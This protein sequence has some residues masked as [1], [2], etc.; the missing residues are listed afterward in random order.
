[1]YSN[2][3]N[4]ISTCPS[5]LAK[6]PFVKQ[7]RHLIEMKCPFPRTFSL[8]YFILNNVLIFLF[9]FLIWNIFIRYFA[10]MFYVIY[11]LCDICFAWCTYIRFKYIRGTNK[12]DTSKQVLVSCLHM[13]QA[14]NMWDVEH[15]FH[16][17]F[18]YCKLLRNYCL[19]L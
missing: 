9:F 6:C 10:Y 19:I 18:R 1:M 15:T 5:G 13:H 4:L 7:K 11:V 12:T 8:N 17:M 3:V 2:E 16:L 14:Y